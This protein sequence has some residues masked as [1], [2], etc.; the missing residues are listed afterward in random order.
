LT[1]EIRLNAQGE[2]KITVIPTEIITPGREVETIVKP[3]AVAR[4]V[5]G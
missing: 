3:I 2:I 1:N 4:G 5:L